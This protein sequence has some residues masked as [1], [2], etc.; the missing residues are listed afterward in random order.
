MN[1][2]RRYF[3][4]I[5][6]LAGL[7]LFGYWALQNIAQVIE[8][9]SWV[10]KLLLPFVIGG[11][12][13]FVFH[14][15]MHSIEM[16]LPAK[17]KKA[18]R[19][20]AFI[21]TLVGI[22]ALLA[23]MTGLVVPQL[24]ATVM[25]ISYAL[26]GFGASI[27]VFLQ[28]ISE[29]FPFLEPMISE[30]ATLNWQTIAENTLTFITQYGSALMGDTFS[31]ASG[32]FGGIVNA[33]VSAIFCVYILFG[34]ET[35]SRQGKMLLYAF[36]PE[37]K[38]ARMLEIGGR[39]KRIFASFLTGQCLEAVILGLIFAVVMAIL[40]MPYIPLISVLIGFTALIPMVGAFIGCGVGALLIAVDDPILALWFC[41]LFVVIQQLEG[42]LIYPRVVGNSI[43]LPSMWVLVSISIGGGVGGVAG[44]LIMIPLASVLY[45]ILC[46]TVYQ[47]LEVRGL[48]QKFLPTPAP[49][50][51]PAT[52]AETTVAEE[53]AQAVEGAPKTVV[54]APAQEAPEK[55][56]E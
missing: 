44:M 36:L 19:V 8:W 34:Q 40:Q 31:A 7:L 25:K 3:R 18:R 56:A 1:I 49:L 28:G 39:S 45:S 35:L 26:P 43:G 42:N 41:L 32:I 55:D 21:A 22:A 51:A 17:W 37:Q 48:L 52:G 15:P 27:L 16:H 12:L 50:D 13:A 47:R 4:E 33:V 9:I 53:A 2:N 24:V 6:T 23:I 38:A 10:A 11:A 14:V 20:L 54:Q 30:W 29:Q 46:E 5:L